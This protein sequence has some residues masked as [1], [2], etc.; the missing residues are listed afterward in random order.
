[1]F[2]KEA[3]DNILNKDLSLMKENFEAA[4]TEKAVQKLEE[5][6]IDIASNYFGQMTEEKVEE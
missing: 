4:L 3:L 5:R 1:M 6:K 2:I